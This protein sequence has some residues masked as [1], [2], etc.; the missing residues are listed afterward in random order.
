M[1]HGEGRNVCS[2]FETS[3]TEQHTTLCVVSLV[4]CNH[5]RNTSLITS[6]AYIGAKQHVKIVL[7]SLWLPRIDFGVQIS[8]NHQAA[9]R[10]SQP[11]A[12]YVA[13]MENKETETTNTSTENVGSVITQGVSVV[14]SDHSETTSTKELAT[15]ASDGPIRNHDTTPKNSDEANTSPESTAQS[16]SNSTTTAS[17]K[18]TSYVPPVKRFS[19]VNINKKFLEKAS[20]STAPSSISH[21]ANASSTAKQNGA[22][23]TPFSFTYGEYIM[24]L[25]LRR[26][27]HILSAS[28]AAISSFT[29]APRD[30]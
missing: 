18:P 11:A 26:L 9:A 14:S 5:H 19:A 25:I 15:T 7:I 21:L 16:Q 3:E 2:L 29:F 6:G 1:V 17:P 22:I 12:S 23:G 30:D 13:C 20:S 10:T 27:F 28:N 4:L 8:S 24:S